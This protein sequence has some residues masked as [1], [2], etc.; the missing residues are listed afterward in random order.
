M[1]LTKWSFLFGCLV[2]LPCM[3]V[4]HHL[5]VDGLL[6]S[7]QFWSMTGNVAVFAHVCIFAWT[8]FLSSYAVSL[9]Q[10]ACVLMSVFLS[11]THCPQFPV[12]ITRAPGLQFLC[13]LSQR[14]CLPLRGASLTVSP[15]IFS[16]FLC[17]LARCLSDPSSDGLSCGS[18][19]LFCIWC[20]SLSPRV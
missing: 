12:S 14:Q 8:H 11:V 15:E 18:S 5:F 20:T 4:P 6:E 16:C 7:F 2:A 3:G 17:S 13:I 10:A 9:E 19:K 1:L